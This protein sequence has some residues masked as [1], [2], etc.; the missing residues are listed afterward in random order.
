MSDF[1]VM[2]A[3]TYDQKRVDRWRGIYIEPKLD[4][5]RV[6][7]HATK[8]KVIYYSRNGR[9]LKMFSHLDDDMRI[10]ARVL[11]T[12]DKAYASGAILDGEMVGINFSDI[13]GAIHRKNATVTTAKFNCFCSL[14]YS[15]FLQGLDT[16][17]QLTRSDVLIKELDGASKGL[18]I[19]KGLPVENHATVMSY[20]KKWRAKGIEGAMVKTMTEPWQATRTYA[21]MKLKEEQS[22]DLPIVGFKEGAGKYEG[23]LGALIVS[24]KG[25]KVPVSGMRDDLRDRIWRNQSKYMG[26]I[27]E[28]SFQL[29]TERGSLRHPRFKTLRPDKD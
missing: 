3:K 14:P 26:R 9:Q 18:L 6:I 25:V 2:L 23:T 28:V 17:T 4:G 1:N 15:S 24:H 8:D 10:A 7:V 13:S 19:V 27:V 5:V 16:E 20:Y 12:T 11:K 29:I 22:L 21:W